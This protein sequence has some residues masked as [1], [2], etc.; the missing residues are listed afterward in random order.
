MAKPKKGG[1]SAQEMAELGA[2]CLDMLMNS[3][4]YYC[5]LP[6]GFKGYIFSEE[7]KDVLLV[8]LMW[9]VRYGWAPKPKGGD[10]K[11]KKKW[12]A[13]EPVEVEPSEAWLKANPPPWGGEP[14]PKFSR[15]PV[16]GPAWR[17]WAEYD[18]TLMLAAEVQLEERA[19]GCTKKVATKTVYARHRKE[20]ELTTLEAFEKHI[21]LPR[22][23][24]LMKAIR[25]KTDAARRSVREQIEKEN[26]LRAER[27]WRDLP[28]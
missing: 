7:E 22:L 17:E 5:E 1:P 6:N 25:E 20:L 8:Y 10:V 4:H 24:G 27:N 18:Q 19:K 9:L 13:P 16:Q 21:S 12:P 26:R 11:L 3:Q 23:K 2:K 28:F 15:G 14:K